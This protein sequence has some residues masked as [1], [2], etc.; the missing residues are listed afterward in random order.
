MR[1]PFALNLDCG[2]L[3]AVVKKATQEVS[4]ASDFAISPDASSLAKTTLGILL[5]FF[6]LLGSLFLYVDVFVD[7][8]AEIETKIEKAKSAFHVVDFATFTWV[9]RALSLL[10]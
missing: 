10:T 8:P 4:Y 5:F 1:R 9:H 3:V 2:T 7:L 6:F